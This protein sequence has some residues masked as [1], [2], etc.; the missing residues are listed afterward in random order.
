MKEYMKILGVGSL[1]VIAGLIL[2]GILGL[3]AMFWIYILDTIGIGYT[4]PWRIV[5]CMTATMF[6]TFLLAS[7][8]IYIINKK[9]RKP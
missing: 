1:I 7:P 5:I 3:I 9:L 6:T 8:F 4:N 2:C